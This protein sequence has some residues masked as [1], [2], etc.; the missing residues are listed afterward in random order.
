MAKGGAR[1]GAGRPKGSFAKSTLDAIAVK[2]HLIEQ[3]Q[4]NAEA[5]HFALIDSAASGDI[6]AIK[7]LFDRV[8]GK[9]LATTEVKNIKEYRLDDSELQKA[10]EGLTQLQKHEISTKTD[11]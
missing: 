5:I 10:A 11:N 4:K 7:E 6:Q 1:P 3:Y 8:Y 2:Q 9:S